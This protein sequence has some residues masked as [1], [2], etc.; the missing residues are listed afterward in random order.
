MDKVSGR[1]VTFRL[2]GKRPDELSFDRLMQYLRTVAELAGSPDRVRLRS[3]RP[4]SVQVDLAVS[5]EEYPVVLG[6]FSSAKNPQLASLAV[7]KAVR[8][9]EDMITE[10]NVR[11]EVVA[12]KTK[13]LQ[14]RGY[15][16]TTGSIIG[17]V[18][19][20]FTVRGQ[21]VGLEGK[22]ATKHAR[23]VESG[24]KREVHG[25]LRDTSL[26]V[27]LKD[28]LWH[29]FVEVSGTARLFRHPDGFWELKA[30]HIERFR[31]L[32]GAKPSDFVRTLR[33]AFKEIDL[34]DDPVAAAKRLRD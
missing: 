31:E 30:F 21:L 14:L 28:C 13:V 16:R 17:P 32:E 5:R 23:I 34:G 4:G 27:R 22:D 26:A 8:K 10:D 2:V 24:T 1:T 3:L 15:T 29:G 9:I 11:V 18:V 20:P 6:R 12:G 19:Q 25:S 7:Q 33:S